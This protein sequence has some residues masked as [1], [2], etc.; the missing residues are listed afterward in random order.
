VYVSHSLFLN[1]Y[2]NEPF[3]FAHLKR[4][5][6]FEFL[7]KCALSL[8]G[9]DTR[10]V[11]TAADAL[12][13]NP[14]VGDTST[15]R[16]DAKLRPES[17]ALFSHLVQLNSLKAYA[18]LLKKSFGLQ[19]ERSF[20][21]AEHHDFV[22]LNVS[23]ERSQGEVLGEGADRKGHREAEREREVVNFRLSSSLIVASSHCLYHSNFALSKESRR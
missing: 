7:V 14:D 20:G 9:H 17:L 4:A 18:L 23:F 13:A 12:P 16:H 3:F 19:A 21:E 2:L 10:A 15:S 1:I 22:V 11:I 8:K 6:G 5:H